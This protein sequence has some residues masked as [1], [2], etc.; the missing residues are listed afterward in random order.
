MKKR[1]YEPDSVRFTA[2]MNR[3]QGIL[4]WIGKN[5][6]MPFLIGETGFSAQVNIQPDSGTHGDTSEQRQYAEIT[7]QQTRDCFG[8]GYSWW[9][10]Q[11]SY[12]GNSIYEDSF[13]LLDGGI[14]MPPCSALEKPVVK[15]FENFDPTGAVYGC[16]PPANYFD[17]WNHELFSPDTNRFRGHIRD[18]L[19][20]QPVK[21]AVVSARTLYR[22]STSPPDTSYDYTYTFTDSLGNFR[23]RPFDSI[24]QNLTDKVIDFYI[25]AFGSER[26]LRQI[27]N[28]SAPLIDNSI[29]NLKQKKWDFDGVIKDDTVHTGEVELMQGWNSLMLSDVILEAGA[30]VNIHARR[31]IDI[32]NYFESSYGS[33]VAID[34]IP[35]F[36]VC[37]DYYD[38]DK[39]STG[40]L[41]DTTFINKST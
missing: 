21:D 18:F 26:L 2:M 33:E 6:Q 34:C 19:D 36:S 37:S 15:A 7:L 29:Y 12:W 11:N 41:Q 27:G 38:F 35:T 3:V 14:C 40:F 17:P 31:E 1:M 16:N 39:K 5:C 10:Y 22:I 24:T 20:Q 23:I 4:Y 32:S 25:S 13:G 28:P 30:Q 9:K 8:S